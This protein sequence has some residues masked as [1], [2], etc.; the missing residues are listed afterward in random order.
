MAQIML[1]T[2]YLTGSLTLLH[3]FA[4]ASIMR[5]GRRDN[6]F[7]RSPKSWR[8]PHCTVLQSAGSEH[9]APTLRFL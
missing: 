8:G 1:P 9:W 2:N 5:A 6:Y 4:P 3:A 7:T